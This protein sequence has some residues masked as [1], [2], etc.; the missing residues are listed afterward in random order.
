MQK[1]FSFWSSFFS[2]RKN[3]L[4]YQISDHV[5]KLMRARATKSKFRRENDPWLM[6]SSN[7]WCVHK[8]LVPP[9]ARSFVSFIVYTN[10]PALSFWH[11][12]YVMDMQRSF[13]MLLK[14]CIGVKSIPER[15]HPRKKISH[16][17][18]KLQKRHPNS[19]V[20]WWSPQEFINFLTIRKPPRHQI[21]PYFNHNSFQL[22]DQSLC[23][24]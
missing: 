13:A 1:T 7:H 16:R 5:W 8:E 3:Q 23:F 2:I 18:G 19:N 14:E 17:R 6:L 4:E 10:W 24:Q 21:I 15:S 9:R 20:E 11:W 12:N 22:S